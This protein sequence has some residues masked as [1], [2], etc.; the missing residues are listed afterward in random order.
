MV[1]ELSAR[2]EKK[3]EDAEG[4]ALLARSYVRLERYRDSLGPYSEA[5]SRASGDS[6]LAAE[7]AEA[8]VLANDGVVDAIAVSLFRELEKNAPSEA[9]ELAFQARYYLALN[10]AQSGDLAGGLK[11]WRDLR[12][13]APPGAT[14]IAMLDEQITSAEQALSGAPLPPSRSEPTVKGPSQADVEAASRMSD[15][16]RQQMIETMVEG[17]ATR[18]KATPDDIQGWRQLARSY[19]VLGR[20]QDARNAWRRVAA[21]DPSAEDAAAALSKLR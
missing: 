14:W 21:L 7:Y 10:L 18:L 1:K 17:L 8:R 9:P 2:L 6:Q 4:W 13:D 15:S 5:L 20:S 16:Q 11:G 12:S 3:P 19:E